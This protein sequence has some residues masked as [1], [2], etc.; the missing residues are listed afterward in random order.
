MEPEIPNPHPSNF[1]SFFF[2]PT[3][4]MAIWHLSLYLVRH[5]AKIGEPDGEGRLAAL[6]VLPEARPDPIMLRIIRQGRIY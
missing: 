2:F 3:T 4:H 1:T 6:T 5:D